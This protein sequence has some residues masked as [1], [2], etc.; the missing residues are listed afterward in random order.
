MYLSPPIFTKR[1]I[2]GNLITWYVPMKKSETDRVK[3]NMPTGI[4]QRSLLWFFRI[5]L[6]LRTS[7][8]IT[9]L[10]ITSVPGNDCN[11]FKSCHDHC[12]FFCATIMIS[13]LQLL[14]PCHAH[15]HQVAIMPWCVQLHCNIAA[16]TLWSRINFYKGKIYLQRL[17][18]CHIILWVQ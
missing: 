1:L 11:L 16:T 14:K 10:A 2:L 18:L 8:M 9:I 4:S 7:S 15:K 13:I 3:I 5:S 6:H 17:P 12:R